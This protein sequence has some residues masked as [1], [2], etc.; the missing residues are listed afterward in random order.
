MKRILLFFCLLIL[1]CGCGN[2]DEFAGYSNQEIYDLGYE[3]GYKRALDA[4]KDNAQY[5][6]EYYMDVEDIED[7]IYQYFGHTMEADEIRDAI[8]YNPYTVEEIVEKL[9]EEG[10]F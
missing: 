10:Y 2:T 9:I 8:V 4:V 7:S 3:E 1:L 6:Y 5:R